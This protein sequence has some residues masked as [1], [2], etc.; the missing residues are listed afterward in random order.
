MSSEPEAVVLA[1][2]PLT[3]GHCGAHTFHKRV[4]VMPGP[5]ASAFGF[6]AVA[7]R[8]SCYICSE[9]TLVHWFAD[10]PR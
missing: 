4:V 3:C 9:C 1:G 5:A 10:E 7:P 8:A 2:K 6:A